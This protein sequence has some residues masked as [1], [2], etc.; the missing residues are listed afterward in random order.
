MDFIVEN[1]IILILFFMKTS[2]LL[3]DK[4]IRFICVVLMRWNFPKLYMFEE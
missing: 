4:I 2:F 1:K 3:E